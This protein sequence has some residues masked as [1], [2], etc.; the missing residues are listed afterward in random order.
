MF[1]GEGRQPQGDVTGKN[2]AVHHLYVRGD[3]DL[4][5]GPQHRC[6]SID[7]FSRGE[8]GERNGDDLICRLSKSKFV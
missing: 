1:D 2:V 6:N 5:S 7:E 4:E 8:S 3:L